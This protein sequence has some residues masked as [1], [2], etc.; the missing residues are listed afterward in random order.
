MGN[1]WLFDGD[2]IEFNTLSFYNTSVHKVL[3]E[4]SRH[5]KEFLQE[6]NHS[7]QT[8]NIFHPY[9]NIQIME[10]NHPFVTFMTNYKKI[11][12]FNNGTLHYNLT[13]P[14]MLDDKCKVQ[15]MPKFIHDHKKAIQIIQWIEP[16]L[17]S[18]YGTP[19][20]FSEMIEYPEN[21]LFSKSSQRCAISRYIGIGTYN[22]DTMETGK[23]LSQPIENTIC[24]S[25]EYWWFHRFYERNAYTKLNEIGL[26]MNFN[27]HYNHGIELRFLEHITNE[28]QLQES[29]DFIILL[30]D[31]I[32]E[33]DDI[34]LFG[35]PITNKIWNDLV[36]NIMIHGKTYEFNEN[37]KQLYEKIFKIQ[38]QS[39]K[40]ID[41]FYQI[42]NELFVRYN[43]I[44]LI[45]LP[46][47]SQT[48]HYPIELGTKN[49]LFL[50]KG[51]MSKLAIEPHIRKIDFQHMYKPS[52]FITNKISDI[53]FSDIERFSSVSLTHNETDQDVEVQPV[54][55]IEPEPEKKKKRNF[56]CLL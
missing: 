48:I 56:C 29:F 12:I 34:L 22:T 8:L 27:K 14:T 4:L 1:Q 38:L 17:I 43:Y 20:P 7:F 16:L 52:F 50:P 51:K 45:P 30:M 55:H 10:K 31:I 18:I 37:E 39:L 3:E 25:L 46:K 33:N 21:H 32:L 41:V 19:D 2:T 44:Q 6:L 23:I 24:N 40:T 11:T 5:K 53:M 35:S 13:L 36:L 15:N 26:D 47:Q 9:G 28:S 42:Y 54:K 49:F